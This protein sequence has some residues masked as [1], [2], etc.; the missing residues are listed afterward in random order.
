M[1]IIQNFFSQLLRP[2][3]VSPSAA[4]S[5]AASKLSSKMSSAVSGAAGKRGARAADSSSSGYADDGDDAFAGAPAPAS[6]PRVP[7]PFFS[8]SSEF[9]VSSLASLCESFFAEICSL[10][11][12]GTPPAPA[13]AAG[14][15][16]SAL[17]VAAQKSRQHPA[18][19]A[20]F[21]R[22]RS[23][24]IYF[25][26]YALGRKIP[27]W[28]S[29]AEERLGIVT[30][31]ELLCHDIEQAVAE[32]R[33][34]EAEVFRACV[35]LGFSGAAAVGA[36]RWRRAAGALARLAPAARPDGLEAA[37]PAPPPLR[38]GPVRRTP[39]PA[40][41]FF[42]LAAALAALTVWQIVHAPAAY[43]GRMAALRAVADSE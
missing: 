29:I 31:E 36:E 13:Y 28:R 20:G 27:G 41:F 4:S 43:R 2:F 35:G 37:N 15:A 34:E 32:E 9:A 42:V 17:D 18:L 7:I 33:S 14:R 1:G 19:E 38:S 16:L 12:D 30:G 8:S 5:K 25:A 26:D 39:W 24:L 3:A 6:G 22:V 11:S 40:V 23:D 21:R 10:R